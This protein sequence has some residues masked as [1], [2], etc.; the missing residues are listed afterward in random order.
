MAGLPALRSRPRSGWLRQVFEHRTRGFW[1]DGGML[2][3]MD[4]RDHMRAA[5]ADRAAVADQLQRALNEGRL[6]LGEYDERLRRAYAAKTYADF[7]GLL[8]DLPGTLPIERAQLVP[9]GGAGTVP[10]QPGPD[11]RYPGATRAWLAD[12]WDG[13]FV[14]LGIVVAIWAA[15]SLMATDLLYFWPGWVGGP[16]GAVLLGITITGLAN[17]EPQRWAAKRAAN[18]QFKIDKRNRRRTERAGEGEPA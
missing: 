3:V 16:W 11:G 6:D 9:A 2:V 1:T 12:T 17:G 5:D 18:Q 10:L 4:R 8:D 15:T 14:V 13:Y 7:D